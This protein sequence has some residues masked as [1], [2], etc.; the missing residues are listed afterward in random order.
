MGVDQT[1]GASVGSSESLGVAVAIRLEVDD[2]VL[3]LALHHVAQTS[4]LSVV[5]NPAAE[6]IDVVDT[7]RPAS[8]G[9]AGERLRSP[10]SLTAWRM[11]RSTP[12]LRRPCRLPSRRSA[13]AA[14]SSPPRCSTSDAESRP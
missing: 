2:E 9:A 8:G 12:P 14:S 5:R 4:K 13:W 10:P 3:Q 6:A 11:A 7:Y 1:V